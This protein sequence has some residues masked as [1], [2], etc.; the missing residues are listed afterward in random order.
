MHQWWRGQA[1]G[2]RIFIGVVVVLL[3]L[4]I[5]GYSTGRWNQE[6]PNQQQQ[7]N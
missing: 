6:L 7:E 1:F 2:V 5:I 4:A 3:A